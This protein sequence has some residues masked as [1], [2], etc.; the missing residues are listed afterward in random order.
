M[1][2]SMVESALSQYKKTLRC[3]LSNKS[4][5]TEHWKKA[6]MGINSSAFH[7]DGKADFLHPPSQNGWLINITAAQQE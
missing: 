1:I 2:V 4:P 7:K 6:S 3:P 5:H